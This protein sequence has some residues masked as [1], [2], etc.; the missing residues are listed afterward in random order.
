MSY[1]NPYPHRVS[2]RLSDLDMTTVTEIGRQLG[3]RGIVPFTDVLRFLLADWS[4]RQRGA[5]S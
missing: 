3:H 4:R 2:A 1:T 5:A